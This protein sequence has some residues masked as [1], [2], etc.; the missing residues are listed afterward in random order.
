MYTYSH[1]KMSPGSKR[2]QKQ[3]GHLSRVAE[4]TRGCGVESQYTFFRIIIKGLMNCSASSRQ[5]GGH[6]R[7]VGVLLTYPKYWLYPVL[8]CSE[9]PSCYLHTQV[10]VLWVVILFLCSWS[11]CSCARSPSTRS[12][13]IMLDISLIILFLVS[14]ILLNIN[15]TRMINPLLL[16]SD[17]HPH[18][19]IEVPA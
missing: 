6:E 11:L 5:A 2:T 10:P 12:T 3:R 17:T 1:F 19:Q 7:K 13:C 9:W 18:P 8:H 4:C 15:R 16:L 14:T